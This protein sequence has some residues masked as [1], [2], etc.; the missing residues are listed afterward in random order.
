MSARVFEAMRGMVTRGRIVM[1]ALNPKRTLVQL[2]GLAD[3]TKTQ[4]ELILP[5]GMSAWP[6]DGDDTGAP[7][8]IMLQVGGSRAHLVV[9]GADDPRL[10]IQDL[11]KG[12]FGFRDK[13]GQ[14]IVLRHDRI[15]VTTPLKLVANITGD[16]DLTV[17]GQC[18]L[19]I[20]GKTI[21]TCNDIELGAAG[22]KKIALD[23]DPVVGGMVQ[24]SS[25]KV[26]AT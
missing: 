18:N 19:N 7:D 24:A 25:T 8:V 16:C 10:R 17:S 21:L 26:K 4:I 5:Y 15:E 23:G 12:E 1:A 9:L 14:Q 11:Q 22:G 13:N 20:T 3:E 6:A 2:S